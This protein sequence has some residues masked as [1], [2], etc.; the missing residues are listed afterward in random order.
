MPDEN[1]PYLLPPDEAARQKQLQD[2]I[3]KLKA[4]KEENSEQE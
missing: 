4:K 2:M 1:R 3:D